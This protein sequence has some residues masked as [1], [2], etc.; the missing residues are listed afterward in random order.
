MKFTIVSALCDISRDKWDTHSRSMSDYLGYMEKVLLR[1]PAEMILFVEK[2]FVEFV[3]FFRKDLPTKIIEISAEDCVLYSDFDKIVQIQ[4]VDNRD[5]Y[6]ADPLCPE[7]SKP[8]YPI[9]VN[10][11]IEFLKRASDISTNDILI[12][13]DAGFC[14][15]KITLD[16]GKVWNPTRYLDRAMEGKIVMNRFSSNL[17][18][19]DPL[20][21]FICHQDFLD[22]GMIVIHRHKINDFRDRYYQMIS[23]FINNLKI[24]DD[25]Q[26][27]MTMM[28]ISNSEEFYLNV[29]QNWDDRFSLFE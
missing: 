26:Y 6:I 21:F 29:F 22:G 16:H 25:D 8:L 4:E 2:D 18:T 1:I 15:G 11:K 3:Q 10:N 28:Y 5:R 13:L 19:V 23:D 9:I 12:W 27:F 17:A 20:K 7:I 24:I 14:H